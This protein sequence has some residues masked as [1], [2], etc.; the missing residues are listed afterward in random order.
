MFRIVFQSCGFVLCVRI[1]FLVVCFRRV[2]V[3]RCIYI[4][5][6]VVCY[7]YSVFSLWRVVLYACFAF[8]IVI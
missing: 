7:L 2:L 1:V 5:V 4:C 8:N 6:C 3:L